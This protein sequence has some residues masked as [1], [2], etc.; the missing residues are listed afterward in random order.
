MR[1]RRCRSRRKFLTRAVCTSQLEE[2]RRRGGKKVPAKSV[3]QEVPVRPV[4]MVEKMVPVKTKDP[5]TEEVGR[6]CEGQGKNSKSS[7]GIAHMVPVKQ[8]APVK[9]A[10]VK[11]EP[12]SGVRTTLTSEQCGKKDRQELRDQTC[13]S[14]KHSKGARKAECR[15]VRTSP[16]AKEIQATQ[17]AD[18]LTD[19]GAKKE[20]AQQPNIDQ[21]AYA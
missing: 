10:R 12:V 9:E 16:V 18:A 6:M 21:L 5:V 19:G 7:T 17:V 15:A 1:V 3:K 11:R 20:E 14:S 8:E 13:S 2:D 4:V